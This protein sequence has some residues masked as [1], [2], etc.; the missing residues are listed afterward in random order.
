MHNGKGASWCLVR[1]GA[2]P[3]GVRQAC[4]VP[5][6]M[7]G[8]AGSG[9]V[10]R[11]LGP[12]AGGG[13]D[14]AASL[15]REPIFSGGS[16][17][18]WW[19]S[20]TMLS[21]S[22]CRLV[23]SWWVGFHFRPERAVFSPEWGG[24]IFNGA[25]ARGVWEMS[26]GGAGEVSGTPFLKSRCAPGVKSAVIGAAVFLG[27]LPTRGLLGGACPSSLP[28]LMRW[29]NSARQNYQRSSKGGRGAFSL[30]L[31]RWGGVGAA[32]LHHRHHSSGNLAEGSGHFR[33]VSCRLNLAL[34]EPQVA[35]KVLGVSSHL[36]G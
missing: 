28:F 36:S 4:P 26:S 16:R 5:S 3:L 19:R 30:E 22:R 18:M 32:G 2:R 24:S 25:A 9:E 13:V 6:G 7:P 17:F 35:I 34:Q 21:I 31:W 29:I 1:R 33:R 27:G 23:A 15:L 12:T 14:C 11:L 10:S 20:R 8:V